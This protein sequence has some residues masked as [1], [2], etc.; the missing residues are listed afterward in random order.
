MFI[1]ERTK[2]GLLR[3]ALSFTLLAS[4]AALAQGTLAIPHAIDGYPTNI[5]LLILGHS[6]SGQ[7]AYPAK[8]A[9]ALNE[10]P[11][12]ADGRHYMVVTAITAGDGGLLWSLLSASPGDSRYD[13]VRAS[14]GTQWCEDA[15]GV[16]WSCRRAKLEHVLGGQFA[17]PATG[18]CSNPA[19]V[20]SCS[21]P[22]AMACTWFDRTLPIE[23]NPVTQSLPPSQCL[24]R[25][26]FVLA[27]V[28]DT[29]SRSWPID[30][31]DGDGDVD[32][33]ELWPASRIRAEALPCG[34]G[35]GVIDGMVDWD[36]DGG[37][38]AGDVARDVYASWLETLALFLLTP[39]LGEAADFVLFGHKPLEMG[40]C[41]LYPESERATCLAGPHAVRSPEQIDAT[42]DR[43][44]DHYYVPTVYWE[45]RSFSRLAALPGLDSRILA[46]TPKN[47]LA[48]WQRSERCYSSGLTAGDWSIPTSIANR[49]GNVAA[50]DSEAD[51]GPDADAASVGCMTADHIHHNESG[52]WMMA[53]VWY[54][55]LAPRLFPG[56]FAD[57]FESG[58][59]GAWSNSQP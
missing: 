17:V 50:D 55:A 31:F 34:G 38:G 48:M 9:A 56:L 47:G 23:L 36:C 45:E 10:N 16:R 7:G 3:A 44:F 35:G 11:S 1:E 22:A 37:L 21:A 25:M 49:P 15:A 54:G 43:P 57:G 26:D 27:L 32:D 8:L 24:Q 58:T 4:E 51:D 14:G 59:P 13:R 42:P 41:S 28:Q 12:G 33:E 53:D 29:T 20:S 39:D 19:F 40:Q 6:T 5:G 2:Q 52:G 18:T 46:A 30:D